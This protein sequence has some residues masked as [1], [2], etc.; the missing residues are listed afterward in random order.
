MQSVLNCGMVWAQGATAEDI[1]SLCDKESSSD[2]PKG[3]KIALIEICMTV[4]TRLNG[5]DLEGLHKQ[6]GLLHIHLHLTHVHHF[7]K[8]HSVEWGDWTLL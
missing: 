5:V 1:S 4:H 2:T 3:E 6:Q 8:L 7:I